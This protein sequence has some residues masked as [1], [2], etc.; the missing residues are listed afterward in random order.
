MRVPSTFWSDLIYKDDAAHYVVLFYLLS[1]PGITLLTIMTD[2]SP[3]AEAA[4][5]PVADSKVQP[6]NR[7]LQFRN[8]GVWT[9]MQELRN[10]TFWVL[11]A[12]TIIDYIKEMAVT[13]PLIYTFMKE[14][15]DVAPWIMKFYLASLIWSSTEVNTLL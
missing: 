2:K 12:Q 8:I 5:G 14:C 13:L 15:H 4:P 9:V 7:Q 1:L 6:S 10:D 11:S 3:T